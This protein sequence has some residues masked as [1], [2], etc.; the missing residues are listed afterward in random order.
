[1]CTTSVAHVLTGNSRYHC[2]IPLPSNGRED[3]LSQGL[4]CLLRVHLLERGKLCGIF[5]RC[6]E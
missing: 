1:M 6:L 2:D 4:Q 5:H 3:L